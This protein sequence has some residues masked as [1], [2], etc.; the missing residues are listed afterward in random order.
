MRLPFRLSIVLAAVAAAISVLVIP[1]SATPAP[2][3]D[4]AC[5]WVGQHASPGQRAAEVLARMTLDQKIQMVHGDNNS[6]YAGQIPAIPQLC[7][8]AL[9]LEDGPSG[10]GDG[11]TGV[12]QLPAPVAAAASWDPSLVSQYG[13]VIGNEQWGKGANVD[14]GPTVNI[15]RDPR[16]GRAFE[17]YGEDPYLAGQ[18]GVADIK[19]IQSQGVLAQVKHLAVYN[20]ETNRNTAADDAIVDPRTLNEIYL[21]QFQAAVQQGDVASVMCS[22]STINGSPACQDDYTQNQKLKNQWGFQGFVTSDWG[23]TH[24]TVASA[25]NGLDME[26]PDDQYFGAPLETAVQD[27]QVPL[28]QLNDMVT[29]ILTEEFRFGLFDRPATGSPSAVVTNSQHA[30]VAQNVAEAGTVLLKNAN[31][32]LPLNTHSTSSIAVIGDDAGPDALTSGGGSAS[33]TAPSIVTP[34]QGISAR[35]GKSVDVQYAQ[36]TYPAGGQLPVVGTQY[37]TPTSGTGNGLTAQYFNNMTLSGTPVLT[38]TDPNVNFDW[39]PNSAV[40]PGPGVNA[41]QWSAKWTGSITAPVTGSYTFSLT[42][43]DGSRLYIN[44]QE[45]IDNW[46][47]QG[48]N[49]ETGTVTLT[50]GQPVSVEA[51][52]YQDGGDD[53]VNLGWQIPGQPT[54]LDQAVALAKA[55]SVAVVFASNFESEGSDLTDIDL[56][57]QQ[58]QLISAVAAVNPNTVVVLNTGSAVTMPWLDSVKGVLEAWYPGQEDGTAIASVLFGDTNPAGKLPVTFPKSLTDVP[59]STAAQW[60]GV[61]GQVDYSEGLDVG[62]RWYDAKG[63]APLFP[64]GAGLSYTTFGFSHLRVGPGNLGPNGQETVT[65][66]ITNTGHRAGAD[67][68]QL[69]LG[70][71]ASATE[72]PEQLKGFQKVQ[73]APGQTKQV[74]FTLSSQDVSYWDSNAQN[75]TTAAGRYQIM[76]GDSSAN[77]PLTGSFQV[78]RTTGPRYVKV[79]APAIQN[80]GATATVSATFTNGSTETVRD[81]ALKLAAPAGWQVSP[82]KPTRGADVGPGKSVTAN[83]QVTAPAGAAAGGVTLTATTSYRGD[84]NR[85]AQV[86]GTTSVSVPYQSLASAANNTGISD[87][88]SPTDANFDGGGYSYSAQALAAV[89]LTPGATVSHDGL[90]FTWPSAATANPDNVETAGQTFAMSGSG[91]QLAFFGTGTFGTQSGQVTITYT[92][93]STSTGTLSL[94]D[95]Y[96]N[97]ASTGNELVATTAHWNVPPTNT[98]DPNHQVSVYDTTV[99]LTAGKT[100]AAVTLPSNADLHVFAAS[101]S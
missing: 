20:Q 11:M 18:I 92:D 100:V 70:E 8:P 91:S 88:A 40:S 22:Y 41:T 81:A 23:A 36:G 5:P 43:D 38:Q 27:G 7:V 76:V 37:F 86:T 69:Y 31:S 67:V 80:A 45:I 71:P 10:V 73:L 21:P 65:A 50:A 15:V 1:T 75:W 84:D 79:S 33:V 66:D 95:W 2:P 60:P 101:I 19:G 54:P 48:A 28:S 6:P 39:G 49:T 68:V 87:D 34:F 46:R 4:P 26:M 74:H 30:A 63:I 29:R 42:S 53:L 64:F 99:P 35:A 82:A 59:A 9:N 17:S 12:T 61:N 47:D 93:G 97:A 90:S 3:V 14:L 62:Y 16:W 55:S 51:D 13:A 89:G 32:V 83:W 96:A 25:N 58:D 57:S 77:L 98:L 78:T 56:S 85:P 94:P 52:Y 24:S 44:G 72:P